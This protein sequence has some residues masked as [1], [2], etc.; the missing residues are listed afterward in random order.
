MT[1]LCRWCS[2]VRRDGDEALFE[3]R[4]TDLCRRAE[5]K[6]EVAVGDFLSPGEAAMAKTILA[7]LRPEGIPL[8][9]GGYAGSERVR[10]VILPPYMEPEEPLDGSTL[11]RLYPDVAR[12]AVAA[13]LVKGSGFRK[14]SHRDYMGSVL[15]LGLERAVIGDI[16][17]Q[18]E[19]SAVIFC[20]PRIQ[21][22]LAQELK[23]IGNDAV[24]I[25]NFDVPE[26]FTVERQFKPVRDTIASP[27]LDC[28]VAA[29]AGLS[30]E[31]AQMTIR[32]EAVEVDHLPED[33][34]DRIVAAGSIIAIRRVG[35]F[36][37]RSVDEQTKK[38]RYRLEADMYI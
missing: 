1:A 34:V 15:A 27:R 13:I 28:I 21:P 18:D 24:R 7:R 31:K 11:S 12:D 17:L 2:D 38:G 20:D 35:K 33:R 19:C 22:Y 6:Y 8:F 3:A 4:L 32:A 30:R 14:L 23:K 29:L 36:V 37:V 9:F 26:G 16:I 10:V 5:T 25:E